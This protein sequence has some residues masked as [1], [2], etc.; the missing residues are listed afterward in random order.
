MN[1]RK[2]FFIH[3]MKTA[4]TTFRFLLE[5]S[6]G[7]NIY[8]SAEELS[9]QKNTW[10]LPCNEFVQAIRNNH[11]ELNQ[12]RVICGHY[13]Y[14]YGEKILNS[15]FIASFIREHISRTISMIGHFKQINSD[16]SGYDISEILKIESFVKN[17]IEN[18]Q[19]KIFAINR[20]DIPSVNFAYPIDDESYN[21]A[22]A[23]MLKL[24]FLGITEQF[25]F[26]SKIF[27]MKTGINIIYNQDDRFNTGQSQSV[28]YDDIQKIKDLVY[29]DLKL[30]EEGMI[31]F[32]SYVNLI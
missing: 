15:P 30:Y 26:S 27:S 12:K 1:E 32:D 16:Y 2:I 21:L 29:Y 3:I 9:K 11:K 19:T 4:G 20:I 17:Q 6:L 7:Q 31:K 10:Y 25:E 14:I 23:R 5:R 8:P 22:R 28:T 13:P 18:Y 24:D